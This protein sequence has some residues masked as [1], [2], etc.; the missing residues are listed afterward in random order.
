MLWKRKESIPALYVKTLANW[1]GP[2]FAIGEIFQLARTVAPCY[3][4]FEDLDSVVTDEVRSFFLNAVDGIQKNDGI[5]MVGSTNHLERLDPGISKRPS[6]FDR[7]FR[8]DNP[9]TEERTAYMKFW[10]KK[11]SDQDDVE[12]PDKLCPAI[13][14][15]TKGFSFAYLQ[16]AM[17][18]SL[19]VIARDGAD[20]FSEIDAEGCI[21][22]TCLECMEGQRILLL[23]IESALSRN[24]T[25]FV[26]VHSKPENG[27]TC[28]RS[29]TCRPFKGLYDFVWTVRQ[30]DD[31]DPDLDNYLLWREVKKQVRILREELDNE[32]A[33][34][35]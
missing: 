28:D 19:L 31:E 2:E 33:N 16:E 17:I 30:T 11:L 26:A 24:S 12:M 3:L 32:T 35:R 1:N 15:I 18:A 8:F 9:D 23:Y 22:K 29:E 25:D 27:R 13:A 4:I 5:F 20:G 7:K 14:K 34:R 10:Q 21:Q 6:R